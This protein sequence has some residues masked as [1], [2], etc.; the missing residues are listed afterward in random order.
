ML[1]NQEEGLN[2]S[3]LN[4]LAYFA[5]I[6]D[7]E[8]SFFKEKNRGK[9]YYPTISC[10][11]TDKDVILALKKYFKVGNVNEFPPRKKHW[12]TSYR[13]RVRGASAIEILKVIKKYLSI[14]RKE[15]VKFLIKEFPNVAKRN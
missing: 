2:L 3:G 13:W 12:K 1:F 8:G 7:G 4:N 11:M 15:K 5:G 9:H 10:E 6:L 14:R